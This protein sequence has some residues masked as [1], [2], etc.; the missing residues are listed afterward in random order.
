MCLVLRRN[1]IFLQC[2][3]SW[4]QLV[5]FGR[6]KVLFLCMFYFTH[7]IFF[8]LQ[9]TFIQQLRA[10]WYVLL[11]QLWLWY[12]TDLTYVYRSNQFHSQSFG[13]KLYNLSTIVCLCTSFSLSNCVLKIGYFCTCV[14]MCIFRVH[15]ALGNT[16]IPDH[17][18]LSRK[19]SWMTSPN[20]WVM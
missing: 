8:D 11:K 1:L 2:F 15:T 4:I 7:S 6:L 14:Y 17:V 13:F 9:L 19:A 10:H 5:L 16:C 18:F 20:K 12:G 3:L